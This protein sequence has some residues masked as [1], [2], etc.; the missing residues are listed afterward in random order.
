M[1]KGIHPELRDVVFQDVSCN[2]TF[3][4]K[5][6]VETKDTIDIS[7]K[8]YPLVKVDISSASHPFYTGQQ[9]LVDTQGRTEKFLK[10]YGK[11]YSG[12]S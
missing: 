3:I 6:A 1:K 2:Q 4:I 12:K 7:G 9:R 8:T 5:S 11:M 10:K